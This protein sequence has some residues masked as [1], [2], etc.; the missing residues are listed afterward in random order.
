MYINS[1]TY[2]DRYLI[3]YMAIY[4]ESHWIL[5]MIKTIHLELDIR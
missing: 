5:I 4:D 1:G 2:I 3:I